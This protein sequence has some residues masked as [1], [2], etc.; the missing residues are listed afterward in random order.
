MTD[1]IEKVL[2][3]KNETKKRKNEVTN[4]VSITALHAMKT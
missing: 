4:D 3:K 2:K 1:R